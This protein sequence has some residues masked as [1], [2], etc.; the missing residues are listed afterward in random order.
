MERMSLGS[1]ARLTLVLAPPGFGKTTLL[2]E[3]AR[4]ATSATGRVAWLSLDPEDNDRAT[5]WAYVVMA[6]EAVS[7]R[8]RA[9][10]GELGRAGR[11]ATDHVREGSPSSLP[12]GCLLQP[13]RTSHRRVM[14]QI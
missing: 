9:A 14:W 12:L 8:I 11:A 3:W 6:L 13:T 7:P 2:A 5:F 10:G 4:V 1:S